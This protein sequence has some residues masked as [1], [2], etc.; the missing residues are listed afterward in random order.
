MA[1]YVV[2]MCSALVH[3]NKIGFNMKST[4]TQY[5][6]SMDSYGPM[7]P[8]WGCGSVGAQKVPNMNS[9]DT[10]MASYNTIWVHIDPKMHPIG[11]HMDPRLP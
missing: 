10:N 2:D 11:I 1:P 7:N 8:M 5:R 4:W 3:M 9:Q 6:S